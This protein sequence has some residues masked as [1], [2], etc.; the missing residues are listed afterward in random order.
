MSITLH[1][2]ARDWYTV[3]PDYWRLDYPPLSAYQSWLSGK[4]VGWFDGGSV[5]GVAASR[6]REGVWGKVGMRVSVLL[7][8]VGV[9]LVAGVVTWWGRTTGKKRTHCDD[10]DDGDDDDDDVSS[11]LAMF[12]L[13]VNPALVLV[14]HGHFQYN[15]VSL[16]LTV[17]AAAWVERGRSGLFSTGRSGGRRRRRRARP[18]LYLDIFYLVASSVAFTLALNHKQMTLYYAPAFGVYLFGLCCVAGPISWGYR[19]GLF[20]GLGLGVVG[21]M[22]GMWGPLVV[23]VGETS[24][25]EGFS[26]SLDRVL[27]IVWRVFP[28]H[29]GLYEDYVANFWC[30]SSMVYKWRVRWDRGALARLCLVG[31]LAASAPAL[32]L[33]FVGVVR[34]GGGDAG[35]DGD[36][37]GEKK[38]TRQSRIF[39]L[40][41]ASVSLSFYLFAFQVHEK[42]ILMAATAVALVGDGK[43]AGRVQ[44]IAMMTMYPLLKKDG[45]VVAYWAMQGLVAVVGGW[46]WWV[47]GTLAVVHAVGGFVRVEG[48][49]FLEDAVMMAGG[50]AWW[51]WLWGW[52][53]WRLWEAGG[54]VGCGGKVVGKGL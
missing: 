8:D 53:V 12:W 50:F 35:G 11:F 42:S 36:G 18:D 30:V 43:V 17:L 4:V 24:W 54:K 49:D 15:S 38:T 6:G 7:A 25:R 45:L 51:V 13:V 19:V 29:R 48:K 46:D 31:T 26:V 1:T 10:G 16:G 32:V 40:M 3:S 23:D 2:P 21:T 28:V 37:D 14:D 33:G 47:G 34:P 9:Y 41:L 5:G 27:R 22:V 39:P 20:V 44:S 52:L